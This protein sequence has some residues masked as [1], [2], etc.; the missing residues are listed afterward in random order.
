MSKKLIT[1]DDFLSRVATGTII[2]TGTDNEKYISSKALADSEYEKGGGS[3]NKW[4]ALAK[5]TDFNDQ[6]PSTSTITMVTDQTANIKPGMAL[7]YKVSG[8]EYYGICTAITSTLLTIGGIALTTGDGDLTE[9]SYCDL[10]NSTE[11]LVFTIPGA[12]ADN[13]SSLLQDDLLMKGG[14][15]WRK[16]EAY[17]VNVACICTDKDSGTVTSEAKINIDTGGDALN[18]DL[19][20]NTITEKTI[21]EIN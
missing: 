13:L 12:F 6:A 17:L 4:T 10:P 11:V 2:N 21:V 1:D 14:F 8:V 20:I 19:E 3:A 15:Y 16:S 5:D 7:K 18:Y 9:L